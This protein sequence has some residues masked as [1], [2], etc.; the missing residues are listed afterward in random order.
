MKTA[1]LFSFLAAAVIGHAAASE[2]K[3]EV[4]HKVPEAECDRKTQK[5]DT[6]SMHYKGTL[7]ASGDKFD[8]S[9]KFI[10]R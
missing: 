10:S 8:A 2:L 1:T 3:V 6:I 9:M 5:G 4:T 7:A